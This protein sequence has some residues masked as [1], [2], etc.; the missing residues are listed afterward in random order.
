M[1]QQ[2]L[3]V[4]SWIL[5][6]VGFIEPP[7]SSH[8]GYYDENPGFYEAGLAI[9]LFILVFY[10]AELFM[11]TYHRRNDKNRSFKEKYI[12]NSKYLF[13]LIFTSIL[14]IDMSVYHALLPQV[15]FRI[16]RL[17]RPCKYSVLRG[18]KYVLGD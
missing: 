18:C 1:W 15:T 14:I 16:S 9:E 12:K 6:F 11:S 8:K 5:L 17:I 10:C 3:Y 2:L 4:M 13:K 7:H